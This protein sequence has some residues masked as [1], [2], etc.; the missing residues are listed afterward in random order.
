MREVLAESLL[1]S[2]AGGLLGLW[3]GVLGI[4]ALLNFYP[5]KLGWIGSAVLDATWWPSLRW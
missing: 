4:R 3:L 5:N 1:L 2:F